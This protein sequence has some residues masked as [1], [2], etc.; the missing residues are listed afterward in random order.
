[1]RPRPITS[2]MFICVSTVALAEEQPR[3]IRGGVIDAAGRPVAG[4]DVA[5]FWSANG[6]PKDEFETLVKKIEQNVHEIWSREGEMQPRGQSPTKTDARGEFTIKCHDR[7]YK[8]MA[9]DESRRTGGVAT[10]DPDHPDQPVTIE[11]KPLVRVHGAFRVAGSD[12]PPEWAH[13][14]VNLPRYQEFPL[15]RVRLV[16]CG[17]YKSRFEF[18]LPPGT[19]A[20]YGN[21]DTPHAETQDDRTLVITGDQREINLGELEL[22][23]TRS[24]DE[25]IDAAKA[26]GRWGDYTK[27]YGSAPPRWYVTAARGVSKGVQSADL[28]GK[29]V[30]LYFWAPDCAPCLSRGLPSLIKFHREHRNERDRFEILAFCLDY[31]KTVSSL[32]E[33]EESLKPVIDRVWD[34]EPL[35]FPVLLD[36][37]FRNYESFGLEGVGELLLINPQGRLVKGDLQ[38]LAEKL[39]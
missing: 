10:L 5:T 16:S 35:P 39:Q 12:T 38:T 3:E 9:L 36:T 29:W 18:L 32:A 34:G 11:L 27:C 1:M 8:L 6:L 28:K 7:D 22:T 23:L 19:Y 17:S 33:L 4:A 13:A 20:L 31:R 24:F 2:V 30:V 21:T 37:T 14:S 15:G 26:A 25:L